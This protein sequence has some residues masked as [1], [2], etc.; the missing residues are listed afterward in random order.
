M[1]DKIIPL[2]IVLGLS[3]FCGFIII[4]PGLGSLDS[5]LNR[6]AAPILCSDRS[7]QIEKDSYVYIPGEGTHQVT[8]YCVDL[9][10]GEK[11]DASK[12]L[13]QVISK[14][15]IVTGFISGLIVFGLAMA[16][17]QWAARRLNTSWEKLF[18]PSI[19]RGT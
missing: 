7:L 8:A 17:L 13:M 10:T 16:F 19:H 2:L 3:L 11:Q 4:A 12:E 6:I 5:H 9:G 18:Q 1:K 15:Q 14:L